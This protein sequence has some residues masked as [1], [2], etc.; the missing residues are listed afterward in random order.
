VLKRT[1]REVLS[2]CPGVSAFLDS[3]IEY[4]SV[5]L[6]K[7]GLQGNRM[8]L[9][10]NRTSEKPKRQLLRRGLPKA[11]EFMNPARRRQ[12]LAISFDGNTALRLIVDFYCPTARMAIEV[13]GGNLSRRICCQR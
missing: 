13:D 11:E 4:V 10:Y 9:V 3:R 2:D 12:I 7:G 8:A 5:P 1:S 6:N